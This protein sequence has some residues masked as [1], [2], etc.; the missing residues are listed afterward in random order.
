MSFK[1]KLYNA[2]IQQ[3]DEKISHLQAALNDLT[4]GAEND[5]KSSAGD[6]HE[7]SRAMMQIEYEKISR[8]LSDA[9]SQKATIEQI[10][11]TKQ[12]AVVQTGSL[13]KTNRGYL[14]MSVALGKMNVDGTEAI[15]LSV[16]SPL[17]QKLSGL[18]AGNVAEINGI[19]YIIEEVL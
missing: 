6:K 17:G 8:Q 4:E 9:F 11:V 16:Q 15:T 10:D 5:S 14:F 7:T 19:Q 1:I 3:L 18:K 2:C 13:I 12:S